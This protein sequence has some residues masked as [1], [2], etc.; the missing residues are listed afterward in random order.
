VGPV[1]FFC[2]ISSLIA[3]SMPDWITLIKPVPLAGESVITMRRE[4][5]VALIINFEQLPIQPPPGCHGIKIPPTSSV[6]NYADTT[7]KVLL[8]LRIRLYGVT[9]KRYYETV[10]ERCERRQ[11]KKKGI[12]SLIDFHAESEII[13][14]K[15]EKIPVEF[16]FCCYSKDHQLGDKEY[17]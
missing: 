11:G 15:G 1:F 12:P 10:C 7:G 9:T 14:L 5:H 8:E 13:E 6:K 2:T 3:S 16:T 17:L 4:T